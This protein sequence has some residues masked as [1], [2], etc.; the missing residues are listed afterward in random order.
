MATS[1]E[2]D[3]RSP[4]SVLYPGSQYKTEIEWVPKAGRPKVAKTEEDLPVNKQSVVA[5]SRAGV[6][7]AEPPTP[8][9][10]G[11]STQMLVT[12]KPDEDPQKQST[13]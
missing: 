12:R 9:R 6:R 8:W 4:F 11:K 1:K 2:I 10:R 5:L 13:D 3:H 7:L